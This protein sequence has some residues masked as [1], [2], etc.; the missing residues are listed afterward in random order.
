M[1]RITLVPADPDWLV[2]AAGM[3]ETL[4]RLFGGIT[5][6]IVHIGSTAV[7]GLDA[8]PKIDLDI[9]LPSDSVAEAERRLV[10]AGF[11]S[12]GDPHGQ[13]LC[14][15]TGDLGLACR[16]YLMAPDHPVHGARVR[17]RDRLRADED[18]RRRYLRLKQRLARLHPEDADA[19]TAGKTRFVACASRSGP[20]PPERH[21]H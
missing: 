11:V 20:F 12:H 7:P 21:G 2:R 19:Y 14:A 1:A 17:F 3:A 6:E 10:G 8:K 4:G 13:G 5:A 15:L 16:L 18:L 9:L